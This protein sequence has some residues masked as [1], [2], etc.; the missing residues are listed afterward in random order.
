MFLGVKTKLTNNN[1]VIYATIDLVFWY[2]CDIMRKPSRETTSRFVV[3]ATIL[4]V[5]DVKKKTNQRIRK[6][7]ILN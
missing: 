2:V 7:L 1:R 4:H 6:N 5:C 3:Y